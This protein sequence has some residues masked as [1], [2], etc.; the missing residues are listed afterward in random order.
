MS[1]NLLRS[2]PSFIITGPRSRRLNG[3]GLLARI[4]FATL[5]ALA[6]GELSGQSE[7]KYNVVFIIADDLNDYVGALEGHP[8]VETPHLDRLAE[9]SVTFTNAQTNAGWCAPSRA[10]FL[11]GIAPWHSGIVTGRPLQHRM[12]R[13]CVSLSAYFKR[14][15]YH[16]VGTGK[17]EH[18]IQ[19]DNWSKHYFGPLYGPF[20]KAE[21]GETKAHPDVPEPFAT[22]G[23]IDGS[24]GALEDAPEKGLGE[25]AYWVSGPVEG[26]RMGTIWSKDYAR[27]K[28]DP[29]LG[30]LTPDE[31]NASLVVDW[32]EGRGD[33]LPEPFFLNLGLARPHTPLHA[34]KRHFDR[35]PEDASVLTEGQ[36]ETIQHFSPEK[37]YQRLGKTNR[38]VHM[39]HYSYET[40]EKGLAKYTAA[41]LASVRAVDVSIG[42]VLDALER[43]PYRDNTIVIVTSDHGWHNGEHEAIG[44][45]STWEESCRIPMFIRVPG[46]TRGGTRVE[47]PVS[48]VDI[49]P[50]LQ[51]L[52]GL[53]GPTFTEGGHPLSGHSLRPLLEYPQKAEWDGG[54]VAITAIS[55]NWIEPREM[56]QMSIGELLEN[57]NYSLRSKRYRY[58]QVA[59]GESYL[60]D[61]EADPIQ[62]HNLSGNP[63][64]R[65]VLEGFA[66]KVEALRYRRL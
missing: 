65:S 64:Y 34:E 52:C 66:Q 41:Y 18:N 40:L 3:R 54:D 5:L 62:K 42:R 11:T 20:W 27:T 26:T 33:S 21:D 50:T 32:L 12:L 2:T 23:R 55:K 9:S 49:Y 43:S 37:N 58:V 15:G 63:H 59:E 13:N 6:A 38:K 22:I 14:N 56:M 30:Y 17:T 51:D 48:L 31:V 35:F 53:V 60:Y 36:R 25:D 10:S 7:G 46:M 1:S 61:L 29:E 16:A 4:L 8:L 57:Q 24:L 39:M 28:Y 44:K 47:Q 19:H 45:N